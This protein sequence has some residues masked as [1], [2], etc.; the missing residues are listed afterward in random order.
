[1]KA[2][3]S[4]GRSA[5]RWTLVAV[6]FLVPMATLVVIRL[7]PELRW[8]PHFPPAFQ[9]ASPAL[10]AGLPIAARFDFPIG[11]ENGA[12]AYNSQAFTD[13]RHLGDDLNGIGGEN[14]DQG[15]PVFAV[16]D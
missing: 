15:D 13:N 5:L 4:K 16:A 3:T 6:A 10:L 1:M 12:F 2:S 9:L 14:S 8:R 11:S 7:F